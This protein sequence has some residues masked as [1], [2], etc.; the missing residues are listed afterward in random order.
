MI[1]RRSILFFFHRIIW[2]QSLLTLPMNC[3]WISEAPNNIRK[4]K[5]SG[6]NLFSLATPKQNVIDVEEGAKA[7]N[8]PNVAKKSISGGVNFMIHVIL[9]CDSIWAFIFFVDSVRIGF[10]IWVEAI[11]CV[12]VIWKKKRNFLLYFGIIMTPIDECRNSCVLISWHI[13]EFHT[14]KVNGM[15]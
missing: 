8:K 12:N 4:K 14:W 6:S 13:I 5:N 11:S 9:Y 3:L 2:W 1:F 15:L 10:I 7:K